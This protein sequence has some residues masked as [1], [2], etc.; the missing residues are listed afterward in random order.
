MEE[1]K[2]RKGGQECSR[3]KD[4][5][6]GVS[7]SRWSGRHPW[8]GY[9]SRKWR[10]Q[11]YGFLFQEEKTV[12]AKAL[13]CEPVWCVRG[14]ARSPGSWSRGLGEG[15][16]RGCQ[17]ESRGQDPQSQGGPVPG[18]PVPSSL[19]TGAQ[20]RVHSWP[21]PETHGKQLCRGT[22]TRATQ[23]GGG[24]AHASSSWSSNLPSLNTCR[25]QQLPPDKWAA[26]ATWRSWAWGR[27]PAFPGWKRITRRR[28]S[29]LKHD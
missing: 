29:E 24:I 27:L 3:G 4:Q 28:G 21:T 14:Q 10:C 16:R 13:K 17:R 22:R 9:V 1:N 6:A 15:N 18:Q 2:A 23:P 26:L 20:D 12:R 7:H 11:L 25:R 8:Y 5:G 19:P